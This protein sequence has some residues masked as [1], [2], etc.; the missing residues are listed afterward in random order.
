MVGMTVAI[1]EWRP[2]GSD[3]QLLQEEFDVL[4]EVLHASVHAGA[5]VSFILPFS[6]D[7]AWEFW[8]DRVLPVM[9]DGSRRVLVARWDDRI[10]GT[11]QL[12]LALPPNQK[13]RA[14]VMKLPVHPDFRGRGI[15]RALMTKLED[16]A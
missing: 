10:V 16:L 4:A 15:A 9:A 1:R 7:D 6:M 3:G 13:H 11:V 2:E 8:R 12:N 14:D 5:S